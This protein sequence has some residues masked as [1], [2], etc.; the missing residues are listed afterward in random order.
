MPDLSAIAQLTQE[1]LRVG[2]DTALLRVK[3]RGGIGTVFLARGRL[4]WSAVAHTRRYLSNRLAEAGISAQL[5]SEVR[6]ARK[7]LS[8]LVDRAVVSR[9]HFTQMLF[10]HSLE[11]LSWLTN[12]PIEHIQVERAAA[13]TPPLSFSFLRVL[14]ELVRQTVGAPAIAWSVPAGVSGLTAVATS[15]MGLPVRLL[16]DEPPLADALRFAALGLEAA[17]LGRGATCFKR[18]EQWW[19][20]RDEGAGLATVLWGRGAHTH[21]WMLRQ[22]RP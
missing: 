18:G 12:E 16:G 14:V 19:F 11:S 3:T 1:V 6:A 17:A 10:D 2:D 22:E 8:D 4:S 15:A 20:A 7:P 9:E 5:I 21:A 13:S